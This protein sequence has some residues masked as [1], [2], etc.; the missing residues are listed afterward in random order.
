MKTLIAILALAPACASADGLADVLARMDQS[1]QSF[2]SLSAKMH[3]VQFTAVLNES[4]TMEGVLHFSRRSVE[5]F[6]MCAERAKILESALRLRHFC[7]SPR[8]AEPLQGRAPSIAIAA[9]PQ[10]DALLAL[11]S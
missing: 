10:E 7:I 4:A 3:R 9:R 11:I 2:R 8:A 6:L 5:T 1:A